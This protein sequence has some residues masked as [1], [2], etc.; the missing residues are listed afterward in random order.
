MQALFQGILFNATKHEEL[1][2]YYLS[3]STGHIGTVF[4]DANR[5]YMSVSDLKKEVSGFALSFDIK[6][7]D[8]QLL[9]YDIVTKEWLSEMMKHKELSVSQLSEFLGGVS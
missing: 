4:L 7:E 6:P 2:A 5:F 3:N 9:N 8:F 1:P